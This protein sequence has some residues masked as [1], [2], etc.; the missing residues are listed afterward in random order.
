M[1]RSDR[2]VKS[3]GLGGSHSVNRLGFGAM[4]ITGKGIWGEP[5]D[6]EECLA[7]LRLLPELG[8]NFIDTADSYG[9]HVSEPLIAEALW[10]YPEGLVIATKGGQVRPGPDRWVPLGRPE[11]LA[12][13]VQMSLRT[14]RLERIPLWQLHRID[15]SVPHDEQFAAVAS[16]I[17]AGW[18]ELAGLSEVTVAEIEEARRYFPVASVQNRYNLAHRQHE[19][20]LDYCETHG[21]AFIPWRPLALGAL[22][23]GDTAVT[24]A[25]REHG[26][27]ARQ[28]A[29]AW[30]LERSE[31]V[32]PIPGTSRPTHLRENVAAADIALTRA[33]FAAID[34]AS[35]SLR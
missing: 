17:E 19:A 9:P 22:G 28:V 32:L 12:Q 23:E 25:A 27:T 13:Q 10:P 24:A 30:L 26:V 18:I 14:L 11:Y 3:F 6:R 2:V 16:F 29:L 31:V 33:E 4:R 7:T 15:R 1:V 20:V 34:A 35:A 8:V 21:I 5:A